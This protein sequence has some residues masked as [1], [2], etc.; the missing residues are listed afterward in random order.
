MNLGTRN[1][2]RSRPGVETLEGRAL[3]TA[4]ALDASF[5]GTGQVV[6]FP[7]YNAFP[8]GLAV[9]P[10][11]KTVVVGG[12]LSSQNAKYPF[13]SYP[14]N[15]SV[16]RY[17]L[18]GS[19]DTSFGS[20]GVVSL[21]T[22]SVQKQRNSDSVALQPDGKIVVAT[23]TTT[24]TYTPETKKSPASFTITSVSMEVLRLNAD[25]SLDTT[26]GTGGKVVL[27][28][29]H[30]SFEATGGVAVLPGGQII[31]AG[32]NVGTYAGPEFLVARLTP[33]GAL[34]MTFGPNGQG[35][36]D[37]TVSSGTGSQEDDVDALGVDASGNIL[38]GGYSTNA[39]ASA[40]SFQAVRFTANGLLDA[41]FANQGV[42]QLAGAH[43]NR[44]IDAIAFQPDGHILLG[45]VALPTPAKPGIVRLNSDGTID[46]TFG[47]NGYFSDANGNPIGDAVAVQPDGKVLIEMNIVTSSTKI[48]VDRLLPGGTLDTSFGT[49]GSMVFPSQS[50][51]LGGPEGLVVGPDGK[52]TGLVQANAANQVPEIGVFRLL[53]DISATAARPAAAPIAPTVRLSALAKAGPIHL[54]G[55][56]AGAESMAPTHP[57]SFVVAGSGVLGMLGDVQMRLDLPVGVGTAPTTLTLTSSAGMLTFAARSVSPGSSRYVLTLIKG[58]GNYS[59]WTGSGS[60][61]VKL[62]GPNRYAHA[63][64]T[65]SSFDLTLRA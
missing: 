7:G 15:T 20:G 13:G 49:G 63:H 58:T 45:L 34:D 50:P 26:F 51:L 57:L 65:K 21:P 36:N 29:P 53:N 31:V 14:V 18:D 9:Q 37:Q 38:L 25:G 62:T 59:G 12:Q 22:T 17:N 6:T 24:Y 3:L 55:S 1:L 10:D 30:A 42:F 4:G 46:T 41:S 8:T 43:G 39:S 5:G 52:I 28:I 11:L 33:A 48:L 35:Y 60:V 19:L 16:V 40:Y 61:T 47:S 64:A 2:R 44:G 54:V 23:N 56:I 27:S 32:T